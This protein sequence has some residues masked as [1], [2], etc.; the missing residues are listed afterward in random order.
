MMLHSTLYFLCLLF[1][2]S[3][4]PIIFVYIMSS[5][6][7]GSSLRKKSKKA[8]REYQRSFYG[9]ARSD[10]DFRQP[11]GPLAQARTSNLN[12]PPLAYDHEEHEN[13]N[14]TS[15]Q[16][17]PSAGETLEDHDQEHILPNQVL[18]HNYM[19]SAKQDSSFSNSS[20]DPTRINDELPKRD[21]NCMNNINRGAYEHHQEFHIMDNVDTTD[22]ADNHCSTEASNS[23]IKAR[24]AASSSLPCFAIQTVLQQMSERVPT[25]N[26]EYLE[27]HE[28]VKLRNLN[29][30]FNLEN[31]HLDENRKEE[32]KL[33]KEYKQLRTIMR[34]EDEQGR[35]GDLSPRLRHT[36]R[37]KINY[38]IPAGQV[39]QNPKSIRV[40]REILDLPHLSDD[41][42]N[43]YVDQLKHAHVT[44]R[45]RGFLSS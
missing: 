27:P 29:S 17:S 33:V 5:I 44:G 21:K 43:Y 32:E 2:I 10:F 9:D 1:D 31:A 26:Y 45:G 16:L 11:G 39:R 42:R 40:L 28:V 8:A 25:R 22:L 20:G 14:I 41:T 23:T 6:P 19:P 13:K 37:N 7:F 4:I 38:R 3:S 36:I 15:T 12:F 24:A 34:M 30:F 18:Y 35:A